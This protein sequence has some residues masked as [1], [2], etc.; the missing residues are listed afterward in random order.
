[1]SFG[2]GAPPT[3]VFPAPPAVPCAAL[4]ESYVSR[5]AEPVEA[6]ILVEC[7]ATCTLAIEATMPLTAHHQLD[8][9][10]TVYSSAGDAYILTRT[11]IVELLG[12]ETSTSIPLGLPS[13][14]SP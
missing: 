6:S 14:I 10:S 5:P 11:P 3:T 13:S 8:I 7:S 2:I 4:H 9:P 1:M 12:Q